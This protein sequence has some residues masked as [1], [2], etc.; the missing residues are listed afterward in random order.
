MSD[1]DIKQTEETSQSEEIE[2]EIEPDQEQETTEQP[3]S[4]A[5]PEPESNLK[6]NLNP[7]RNLKSIQRVSRKGSTNL[8]KNTDVLKETVR[9]RLNWLRN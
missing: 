4:I 3:V 6:L 1:E 9:K 8:L 2:V 7:M 5:Q